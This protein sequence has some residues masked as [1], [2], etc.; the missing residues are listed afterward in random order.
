MKPS[1]ICILGSTGSIGQNTLAVIAL[2][3]ERFK[4]IALTAHNSVDTLY[5][6]C[7][8]FKPAFAVLMEPQAAK[9]LQ[10]KLTQQ[11]ISTK[12]LCGLQDLCEV[13]SLPEVDKVVAA[14]VG[15]AGLLPTLNAIKAGKQILLANKEALIMAGDLFL[16]TA[17]RTGATLLPVDSEHN[18]L[19]QCMPP[20]YQTGSRPQGV[21]RLILTASGG[22]FLKTAKSAFKEITPEMACQHPNWKMGKKITV[23]CATLMNKGLE[24][25]EASKL[26]CFN[27]DEI[28][29]V[30][31]PQSVIHSLVEYHDGSQLAQLGTPDMRIPIAN[32]LAWPERI[33]SGATRLSL[34]QVAELTFL[35]PDVDKFKCLSLAYNALCL[36]KAAPTVLNAS[37]E[38]AVQS[39]LQQQMCFSQIPS[40]I[41]T[42][43]QTFYDLAANSLEEILL[44]DKLARER[45]FDL[46]QAGA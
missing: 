37:N 10:S 1:G 36:G 14:I 28:D 22:P 5:E 42:V 43:L 41:E 2:H 16:A 33:A 21:S 34:T 19:F 29:V 24:V 20:G 27:H 23:D 38:V 46:I 3:P 40:I 9:N 26:F 12:V 39:F 6:Q 44:A 13:V 11:G 17:S 8:I 7:C 30:V 4:V 45:T 35:P 15:A 18:A 31:H 32:C 25:I